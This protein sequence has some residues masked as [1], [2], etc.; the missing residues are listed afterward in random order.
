MEGVRSLQGKCFIRITNFVGDM[1]R[2]DT[3]IHFHKTSLTLTKPCCNPTPSA[4]ASPLYLNRTLDLSTQAS[5]L[6]IKKIL[7]N[8][9]LN[10]YCKKV[11]TFLCS[12]C[13]SSLIN[14]TYLKQLLFYYTCFISLQC[15]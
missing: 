8:F 12:V 15:L 4:V 5:L 9:R 6:G 11:V 2:A 13:N 3:D 7:N 14:S 1:Y 10:I